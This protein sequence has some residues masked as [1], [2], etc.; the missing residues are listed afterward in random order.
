DLGRLAEIALAHRPVIEIEP[1]VEQLAHASFDHVRQFPCHDDQRPLAVG[2]VPSLAHRA[3]LPAMGG[4][5]SSVQASLTAPTDTV[6]VR[7]GGGW[8]A[9]PLS[10]RWLRQDKAVHANP[11]SPD[12]RAGSGAG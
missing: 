8:A 2:H 6:A 3:F 11:L 4:P 7:S 9:R 10:I 1:G 12:G 5:H